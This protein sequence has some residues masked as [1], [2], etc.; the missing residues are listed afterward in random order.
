MDE[1]NHDEKKFVKGLSATE[2]QAAQ[3]VRSF[4]ENYYSSIQE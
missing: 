2:E 1:D 3:E 4:E